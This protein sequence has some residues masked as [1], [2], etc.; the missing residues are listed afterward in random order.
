M[1]HIEISGAFMHNKALLSDHLL[2]SE[3]LYMFT[4]QYFLCYACMSVCVCTCHSFAQEIDASSII[5][6]YSTAWRKFSSLTLLLHR[7]FVP[8]SYYNTDFGLCVLDPMYQPGNF[9]SC[10][11]AHNQCDTIGQFLNFFVVSTWKRQLAPSTPLS[12]VQCNSEKQITRCCLTVFI[13]SNLI[14]H[15]N[16]IE[17]MNI[18]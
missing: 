4:T 7:S 14:L 6:S 3:C 12:N 16:R 10:S 1:Q 8:H 15:L 2:S 5:H 13:C 9:K 17:N 18:C 11:Q